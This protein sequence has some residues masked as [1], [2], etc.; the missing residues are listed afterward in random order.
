MFG[1]LQNALETADN[2]CVIL[3]PQIYK[4]LNL[5][6]DLITSLSS[7][8]THLRDTR[9]H[10]TTWKD[11]IYSSLKGMGGGIPNPSG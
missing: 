3:M 11:Y 5:W 9:P 10:N 6:Q 4:E 8:T 7:R 1:R 2:R